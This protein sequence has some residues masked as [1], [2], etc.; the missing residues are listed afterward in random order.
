MP[1]EQNAKVGA[2]RARA[3]QWEYA[4]HTL[5]GTRSTDKLLIRL[6]VDG[7]KIQSQRTSGKGEAILLLKRLIG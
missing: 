4:F 5:Q 7:W 1:S 3:P 2:I 6:Q